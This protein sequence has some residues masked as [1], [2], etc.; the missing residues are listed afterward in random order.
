MSGRVKYQH[1]DTVHDGRRLDFDDHAAT[2]KAIRQGLNA[3]ADAVRK[4]EGSRAS[5]R[6]RRLSETRMCR[7]E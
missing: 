6:L 7:V 2:S 5:Y 3:E 4:C 1:R